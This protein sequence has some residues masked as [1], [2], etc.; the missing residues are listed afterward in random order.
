MYNQTNPCT[1][2]DLSNEFQAWSCLGFTEFPT[3]E[4]NK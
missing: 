2:W 1:T 3:A 4:Q